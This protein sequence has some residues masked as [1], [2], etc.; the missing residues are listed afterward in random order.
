M[1]LSPATETQITP[2][3]ASRGGD[4]IE[5]CGT[6]QVEISPVGGLLFDLDIEPFAVCGEPVIHRAGCVAV[7]IISDAKED[8]VD[9]DVTVFIAEHDVLRHTNV[10]GSDVSDN[11]AVE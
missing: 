4:D 11:Q 1:R 5:R 8:A 10:P 6:L 3:L 7:A 2:I 9:D